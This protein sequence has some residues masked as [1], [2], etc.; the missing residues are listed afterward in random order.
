MAISTVERPWL[1]CTQE[2]PE[3]SLGV[4]EYLTLYAPDLEVRACRLGEIEH[5]RESS[6]GAIVAVM[7]RDV[8]SNLLRTEDW[9]VV[10]VAASLAEPKLTTV[11]NDGLAMGKKACLH[12]L[13]LGHERLVCVTRSGAGSYVER[14]AEGFLKAADQRGLRAE[15]WNQDEGD[16]FSIESPL[17]VFCVNEGVGRTFQRIVRQRGLAIPHDVAVVCGGNERTI[18]EVSKPNMSAIAVNWRAVGRLAAEVLLTK[19]QG[20][21]VPHL[22]EVPPGELVVR[23]SSG[24]AAIADPLVR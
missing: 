8:E 16:D 18:C 1:L 13:G 9:P 23:A 4:A 21:K 11:R 17:G 6:V 19:A 5:L 22:Q 24:S 2:F 15:L 20:G 10:N 12:L 3:I 7:G 14:R